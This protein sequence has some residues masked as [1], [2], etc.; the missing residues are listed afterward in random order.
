MTLSLKCTCGVRLDI[1]ENFAGQQITCPDCQHPVAVP[2]SDPALIK[3]SGLA[4]ASLLLALVGA[5]TVVGTVLAVLVG[6]A[7]LVHVRRHREAVTGERYAVAGIVLGVLLTVATLYAYHAAE[8]WG[9]RNLMGQAYWTGKLDYTGPKLI[10]RETENYT[11]ERPSERWGVV[12]K[13]QPVKDK[14]GFNPQDARSL[15]E[16]LLINVEEDAHILVL[17]ERQ[18][19]TLD[20]YLEQCREKLRT[21]DIGKVFGSK[22]G[23]RTDH[24]EVLHT[25]RGPQG[26]PVNWIESVIDKRVGGQER[27]FI[28][29][30]V[31]R[32]GEELFYQVIVG[33]RSATL[34]AEPELR[35]ALDN[36]KVLER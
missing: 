28:L 23:A 35:K 2:R 11:I 8:G 12:K 17:T 34:S 30:V 19:G 32:E 9:L 26:E 16:L 4:L 22:A 13:N 21:E 18:D 25:K 3:T 27:R 29:R 7:A 6:L 33:A 1:P 36:F 14:D 24:W 31:Q 15:E 5:F 20:Q 10:K